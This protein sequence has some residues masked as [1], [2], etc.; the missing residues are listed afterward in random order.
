MST[1]AQEPIPAEKAR[2]LAAFD[3]FERNG[4]S[5]SPE[6]IRS[7]RKSAIEQFARL[8]FP[9]TRDEEWKYTKVSPITKLPFEPVFECPLRESIAQ[10]LDRFIFGQKHWN[11]LVFVNG[12]CHRELSSTL[13]LPEG[14]TLANLSETIGSESEVVTQHLARHARY[15]QNIFTA[16]NTAFIRDGAYLHVPPGSV[17]EEPVLL[18]FISTSGEPCVIS[19]PRNLFVLDADSKATVVEH[20]VSLGEDQYFTNVI[21]EAVVGDGAT[22]NHYKVQRESVNAYHISTVRVRQGKGSAYSS[23]AVEIGS[24]IARNNLDVL[25]DDEGCT[26]TLNGLYTVS[27]RQHVDNYIMV[28]HAKPHATS[29]Q[30]FKG[31]LDGNSRAVFNGKVLVRRDAQHT[32]A[33]QTNRNLVLSEGAEVDTMPQLEI[34][35]DDVKCSHGDTVG[36]LEEDAIFYFRSRGLSLESARRLLTYGFATEVINTIEAEPVRAEL[37]ELMLARL[38][39]YAEV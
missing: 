23:C 28:D 27:G 2:Y 22:L 4:G 36:Q 31:I 18:I 3:A 8:R 39:Q 17:V 29:R 32:D 35:A 19:Q 9:T 34:Y 30:L 1:V 25:L 20:Y 6:W 21:T 26:S 13:T 33:Q 15:D 5:R 14:V 24:E 7:V 11:R 12:H 38:Q 16:L 10:D 37:S